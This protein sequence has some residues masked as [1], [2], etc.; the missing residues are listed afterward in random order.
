MFE[1]RG[2]QR[3]RNP[4]DSYRALRDHD[5]V[6]RVDHPVHGS[7]WVLSRF[8]DVFAAVR[9]T[10]T[11]SSAKGLTPDADSMALFDG[12]AAPIV[13]MDPPDHTAMRRLVG[14]PMT[15]R[16]VAA[17]EPAIRETVDKRLDLIDQTVESAGECDIMAMLFKPLPSFVVAHFLGVPF[18]DR[19]RFDDWVDAI[20][21]ANAGGSVMSA[22]EAVVALFSY[23][24]ELIEHRRV[25]PGED[26]VSDLVREDTVSTMW[27]L[28]F[29][30]T[31][32]TGGND[33]TAGL[34]GG[35]A[36][37]LTGHPDQRRMLVDDPN[38]IPN[39]VEEFLRL[40]SPVQ[41][42]ARTTT[43]DVD[44]HGTTIP[45][46][47][48]VMLLYGAANRDDREFGPTADELDVRRP[49]DKM[50]AFG[51]GAHMCLGAAV[52][53]LQAAIAI[54]RL[55]A[56]YPEFDVDAE[57]GRFA[58]GAFVR[59]YESLPFSTGSSFGF[60][61]GSGSGSGSGGS[62]SGGR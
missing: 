3:W 24:M 57:R 11:Y 40:T 1:L 15:P 20:V 56:R 51:Y 31:M 16:H 48:K 33:T 17:L 46:D 19:D 43:R 12:M 8:A 13:M 2:A 35:A 45:A 5:P 26:L 34:L 18:E 22:T 9:D 58:D 62:G 4:Y 44:V 27:I 49:I 37:L 55:L 36:E 21:A 39:A 29:V 54:E 59:R 50:L 41:N 42:L 32:I 38:L 14:R 7:F 25:E 10:E 47:H 6:H 61:F 60:G 52:T 30:F 23:S 28:A 53:R